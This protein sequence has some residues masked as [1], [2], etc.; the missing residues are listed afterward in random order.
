MSA[1]G[2]PLERFYLKTFK[3]VIL[4]VMSL[5]LLASV[6]ALGISAYHYSSASP[7]AV[8]P[9]KPAPAMSLD[10]T[11]LVK[12]L[13]KAEP[14]PAA[15]A[16]RNARGKVVKKATPSPSEPKIFLDEATKLQQC[17]TNFQ[18]QSNPKATAATAGQ[19]ESLRYNIQRIAEARRYDRGQ[20][21]V[22]EAV[23]FVCAVLSHPAVVA[24]AKEGRAKDAFFSSLR[25]HINLWDA[26]KEKIKKHN[27]DEA[28]RVR[29]EEAAESAKV[30]A[31]K[32]T[33]MT[34]L[35]QAGMAFGVF[36]ALAFYLIVAAM[37]SNLRG[38]HE[39]LAAITET[40]K[41]A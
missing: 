35:M 1:S 15:T 17:A 25:V 13:T 19:I 32:A 26:Q 38:I 39:S 22:T 9:A 34:S 30:A 10:M 27:S 31:S 12:E 8:E 5:A 33:A 6:I 24:A 37:E 41:E 14:A 23:R 11:D 29:N 20:P 40:N 7:K 36:L 21:Y 3:I 18:Q 2:S 16:T 4:A 28:E